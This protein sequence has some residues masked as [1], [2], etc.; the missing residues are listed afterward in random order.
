MPLDDTTGS[1]PS[2]DWGLQRATGWRLRRCLGLKTCYLSGKS[3]W[4]KRAYH[5]E[6]WITG[7]GEPVYVD[8]WVERDEFIKWNLRG[9]T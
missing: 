5:G 7:P 6:R 4:F 9:R 8:Y 1:P 2:Q 3:L